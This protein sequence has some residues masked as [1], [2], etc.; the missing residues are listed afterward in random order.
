MIEHVVLIKLKDGTTAEQRRALIEAIKGLRHAVP[1]IVDLSCGENFSPRSQGYEVGLVVRFAD[2][3]ALDGYLP[4]PVH[5]R[6]VK[7]SLELYC[8]LQLERRTGTLESLQAVGFVGCA[9]G[10]ADL[11][12][13]YK[14]ELRSHPAFGRKS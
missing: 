4:H 11:S 10:P 12:T 6:V 14:E 9:E 8:D 1:G 13:R 5:Q 2:R 3:A 7:E